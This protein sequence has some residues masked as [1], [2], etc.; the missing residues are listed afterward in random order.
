MKSV[1]VVAVGL[2]LA[3][4]L[5][6]ACGQSFFS[7]WHGTVLQVWLT[8]F[9]AVSPGVASADGLA[10]IAPALLILLCLACGLFV[11]ATVYA[12]IEDLFTAT[13]YFITFSISFVVRRVVQ[14]TVLGLQVFAAR[15]RGTLNRA[16]SVLHR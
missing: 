1:R 13:G 14:A 3:A 16:F 15:R 9:S 8:A 2:L 6:L 12:L 5:M 10:L 4:G 7:W 11:S